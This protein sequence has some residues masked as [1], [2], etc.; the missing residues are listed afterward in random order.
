MEHG[1][2]H[3]QGRYL[4]GGVNIHRDA[5][6]IIDDFDYVVF[7]DLDGEMSGIVCH[8]FVHAVIHHFVDHLMESGVVLRSDVHT[9]T[10]ADG[11]ETFQNLDFGAAV[12]S[13]LLLGWW[14]LFRRCLF[15]S[16]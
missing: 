8:E 6:S 9:G 12:L 1:H 2:H 7:Q 14:C 3:F 15:H 11:L 4:F 16:R 5:P 10:F 13:Q